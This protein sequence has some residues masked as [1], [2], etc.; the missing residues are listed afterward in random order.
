MVTIALCDD[1]ERSIGKYADLIMKTARKYEIE[2]MLSTFA[3]GEELIFKLCE[4][5]DQVDVIY[6]DIIMEKING[7]D[8]AKEL[9][10]FGC[11]AEIIFLT[12]SGDYVY[13][14]FEVRPV[15]Y[16]LKDITTREKFEDVFLRAVDLSEK[17]AADMFSYESEGTKKLIPLREISFFEIWKRVIMVHYENDKTDEF[18][19]KLELLEEQLKDRDFV[20]VHRS[21]LVHLAYIARFRSQRLILKSGTTIPVGVTYAA[22]VQQAF[23]EYMAHANIISFR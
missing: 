16:L 6:L 11:K 23:S 15:Q 13:D 9:R 18:Y 14:A 21:Y 17:K 8:T 5:P 12:V 4:A 1:D 22:Q 2:I 10:R 3:N 20:R 7:I 19:G